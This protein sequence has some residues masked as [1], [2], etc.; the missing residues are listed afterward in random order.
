MNDISYLLI[1][2]N[3][4]LADNYIISKYNSSTIINC[5]IPFGLLCYYNRNRL[6]EILGI[7]PDRDIDQAGC[8]NYHSVHPISSQ[9]Q[10]LNEG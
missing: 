7:K 3:H 6:G 9:S 4:Y 1:I 10:C 8:K 5:I 2:L